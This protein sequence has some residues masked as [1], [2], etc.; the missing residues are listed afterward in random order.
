MFS[1]L[2]LS[3][4]P[5]H[6]QQKGLGDHPDR[7]IL[8][9]VWGEVPPQ[10]TVAI[11]GPSGAGKTSLLNVLAGRSS[12]HGRIHVTADVRWNN[13]AVDPTDMN[14]RHSI[15]FVAQED[16]LQVT[17]TPREALHFSAK[18]RLP[19]STTNA[20]LHQLTYRM[21]E[22]L[23]L[24][25]CA[26]TIVGSELVKGISGGER[27]R[28]SVGVELVTRPAVLFLDEPTSGLDSFSAVQLCQVLK[29]VAAAGAS[30][31]FTIHQP[32]SEI[33]NSF[34]GVILMNQGRVMYQGS[35]SNVS[36]FFG[37]R[38]YPIPV[39]HNP[40][41]W[42]IVSVIFVCSLFVIFGRVSHAVVLPERRAIRHCC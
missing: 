15:A 27:K 4:L 8:D 23:G 36:A 39:N 17:A 11:L 2:A 6:S 33:F 20:E 35:I 22:E 12:T 28:T 31:L 40:A 5:I 1:E 34:D 9:H 42:I 7:K 16:S 25:N 3:F 10:Q 30:V 29:K 24:T 37:Q 19:R 38:G 32:A 13:Y 26:D 21:L 14:I 18:L 41:D